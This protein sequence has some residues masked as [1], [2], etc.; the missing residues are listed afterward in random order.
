M[1]NVVGVDL[2]GDDLFPYFTSKRADVLVDDG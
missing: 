1:V 2:A